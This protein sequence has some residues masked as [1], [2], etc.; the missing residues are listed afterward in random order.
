MSIDLSSLS[1][2]Y[3]RLS[4]HIVRDISLLF[5]SRVRSHFDPSNDCINRG[6]PIIYFVSE[7][8]YPLGKESVVVNDQKSKD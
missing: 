1:Y 5:R 7:I 2:F 3:K 4:I 8:G 6:R